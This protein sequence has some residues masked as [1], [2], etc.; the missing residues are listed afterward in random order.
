[1]SFTVVVIRMFSCAAI[2]TEGTVI[3][4]ILDEV[5]SYC[6][7]LNSLTLSSVSIEHKRIRN[8]KQYGL[9]SCTIIATA[10]FYLRVFIIHSI[11]KMTPL[12]V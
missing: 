10:E 8:G 4:A 7:S 12:Y 11:W 1:M 9:R 5:F 2:F 3:A 6:G